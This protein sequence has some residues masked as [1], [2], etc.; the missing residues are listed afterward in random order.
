MRPRGRQLSEYVVFKAKIPK[1][2]RVEYI[3][4]EDLPQGWRQTPAP[5]EL[6]LMG[7]EWIARQTTAVL[8]VP[9]AI[10]PLEYNYLLNSF[11]KD[12]SKIKIY[13]YTPFVFDQRLLDMIEALHNHG[14]GSIPP[15]LE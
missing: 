4:P 6:A 11:H 14:S 9:S 12:F 10:V 13:S 5:T 15:K 1:G 2:V 7:D 8:R 3:E